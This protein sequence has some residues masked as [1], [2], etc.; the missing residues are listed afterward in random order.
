[1]KCL[2]AK[3]DYI[4]S[5]GVAAT[6]RAKLLEFIDRA[7]RHDQT[8][9]I[10]E[11]AFRFCRRGHTFEAGEELLQAL[12][13]GV[14]VRLKVYESPDWNEPTGYRWGWLGHL[15]D[16]ELYLA[17]YLDALTPE[18]G[19]YLATNLTFAA[20]MRAMKSSPSSLLQSGKRG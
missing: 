2:I 11:F 14:F 19:E 9:T 20:V 6:P 4:P 10:G 18:A 7:L 5:L 1:M 12:E 16:L 17:P 8:V 3:P 15:D 13:T